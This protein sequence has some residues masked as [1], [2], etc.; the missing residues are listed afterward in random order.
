[1]FFSYL[2]PISLFRVFGVFSL[3]C[4]E[5]ILIL[6]VRNKHSYWLSII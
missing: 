6:M 1:V 5:L 2:G 4:F 3:V